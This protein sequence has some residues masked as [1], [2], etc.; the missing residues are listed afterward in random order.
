MNNPIFNK[1]E[2]LCGTHPRHIDLTVFRFC[3]PPPLLLRFHNAEGH[4]NEWIYSFNSRIQCVSYLQT[5]FAQ[6][7][8]MKNPVETKERSFSLEFFHFFILFCNTITSANHSWILINRELKIMFQESSYLRKRATI[9]E[10]SS[11]ASVV[12]S[13]GTKS[14]CL[15]TDWRS[16]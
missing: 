1:Q 6:C 11:P 9:S 12:P 13:I 4:L 15:I 8:L 5:L 14:R 10:N 2:N 7:S 3:S 16:L